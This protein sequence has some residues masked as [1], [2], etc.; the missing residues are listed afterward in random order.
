MTTVE[1]VALSLLG[2]RQG[3][4]RAIASWLGDPDGASQNGA[5]SGGLSRVLARISRVQV[6]PGDI[7]GALRAAETL[8][9]SRD[10]DVAVVCWDG[11]QYPAALKAIAD[12]PPV[13]WVR[14][15]LAVLR[16]PTVALVGSRAGT[17]HARALARELGTDLVARGVTVVS[18]L[19]RGVDGAA[20][21]GALFG[22]GATVAILGSGVDTVYP[23]EHSDLAAGI[24]DQGALVS[25]LPPGTPPRSAHFPLRNRLISGVAQAVVVVEATERSG[26]LITARLALEQGREVM[27]VPGGVVGRR[28]RGAH[29]LLKD[30]AKLVEDVDDILE[31]L[32]IP[33]VEGVEAPADD[34]EDD[35]LLVQLVRGESYDVDQLVALSG[36]DSPALLV[37]LS[38]LEFAGRVERLAGGRFM[39]VGS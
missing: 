10:P 35:P 17:P 27:A 8:L 18:G 31:E 24:I 3:A 33:S 4:Q 6:E 5:C 39:R 38:E 34:L 2:W 28:N 11:P 16:R 19:A 12:P 1:W 13:L 22:Q 9:G 26:S 14:G 37:R 29:A 25:E 30:G 32:R 15:T 7:A 20:H 36:V 23:P 21:R